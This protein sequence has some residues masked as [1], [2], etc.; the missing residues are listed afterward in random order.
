MTSLEED[1]KLGRSTLRGW[2]IIW[3][4]DAPNTYGSKGKWVYEDTGEDIPANGGKPRPCKKCGK[5]WPVGE[6]MPDPCFGRLPG[7]DNACC[8]H[9]DPTHAY[10]RFT[11]GVVIEGFDKISYTNA[12]KGEKILEYNGN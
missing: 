4:E 2:P 1:K 7:V 9:G 12:Y 3:I 10:I 8:G 11:N 5:L 6:G